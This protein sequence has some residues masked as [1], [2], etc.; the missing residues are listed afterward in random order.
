[1]YLNARKRDVAY[2]SLK[3]FYN[4]AAFAWLMVLALVA[5]TY[6]VMVYTIAPYLMVG[7]LD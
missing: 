5:I 2:T 7:G 6:F 4:S 1:M 3:N